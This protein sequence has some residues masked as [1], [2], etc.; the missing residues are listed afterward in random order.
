MCSELQVCLPS[1]SKELTEIYVLR[2]KIT[3]LRKRKNVNI[4]QDDI[5]VSIKYTYSNEKFF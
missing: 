1:I 2:N 3:A 4:F 5:P